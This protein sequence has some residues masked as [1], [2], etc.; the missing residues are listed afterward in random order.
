MGHK[1]NLYDTR[2][3]CNIVRIAIRMIVLYKKLRSVVL[4][5]IFEKNEL[6]RTKFVFILRRYILREDPHIRIGN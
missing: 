1:I 2:R 6:R 3:Y 4:L 5:K